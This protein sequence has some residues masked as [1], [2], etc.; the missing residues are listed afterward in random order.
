M[1][2]TSPSLPGSSGSEIHKVVLYF[3]IFNCFELSLYSQYLLI[4]ALALPVFVLVSQCNDG[5]TFFD[6]IIF[7]TSPLNNTDCRALSF[8][9]MS[10]PIAVSPICV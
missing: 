2:V 1:V 7:T 6:V 4:A 5:E 9:L 10:H 3:F 8:P